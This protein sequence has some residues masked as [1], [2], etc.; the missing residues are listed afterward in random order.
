MTLTVS[1]VNLEK[2][3]EYSGVAISEGKKVD[4]AFR[5]RNPGKFADKINSFPDATRWSPEAKRQAIELLL[6]GKSSDRDIRSALLKILTN[7]RDPEE[8][9]LVL[10][11]GDSALR[12]FVSGTDE[13]AAIGAELSAIEGRTAVGRSRADADFIDRLK[14]AADG[15]ETVLEILDDP[16]VPQSIKDALIGHYGSVK[17]IRAAAD[18][19]RSWAAASAK[20]D[21][22][23]EMDKIVAHLENAEDLLQRG[24][25]VLSRA[26]RAVNRG[27]PA[28]Q[29][30]SDDYQL[31]PYAKDESVDAGSSGDA[32][33]D[34]DATTLLA[35]LR[36]GE[37]KS[38]D[39]SLAVQ[40]KIQDELQQENRLYTTIS[41]ALNTK[42][43]SA[44]T[45][46]G[47][48]RA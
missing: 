48:T 3:Y 40:L 19:F 26:E 36:S 34:L 47:N 18:Q 8:L 32:F 46:I 22:R 11:D 15:L 5:E 37:L 24:D 39:I 28:E 25:S 14:K 43:E 38:K 21:R 29:S 44:K 16:T 9:R 12:S 2:T 13:A 6:S 20:I 23:A 10:P 17:E 1:D 42:H 33:G 45:I 41:N 35:K 31:P 27:K 7:I 30:E 4:E